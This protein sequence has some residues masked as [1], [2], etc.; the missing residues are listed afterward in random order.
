MLELSK[1]SFPSFSE[2]KC[3]LKKKLSA[4]KCKRRYI[5]LMTSYRTFTEV[6]A[7]TRDFENLFLRFSDLRFINCIGYVCQAFGH[8]ECLYALSMEVT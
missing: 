5:K 4:L 2:V 1:S 3:G 7:F 8:P 6:V